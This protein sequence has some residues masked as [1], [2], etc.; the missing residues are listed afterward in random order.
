MNCPLCKHPG[1][2]FDRDEYFQCTH[3][4]G[5]YKNINHY[6]STEEEISRYQEHNNDVN[7]PRYQKFVSP[8]TNYVLNHFTPN[9][10]GLDFGSGTGP[11]A[12]KVLQD[13]GYQIKQYDPL[14]ANDI[15]RLNETYDYIVSCEVIEHFHHPDVEFKLLYKMLKANGA[16]ICMTHLY[17]NQIPFKT[18]YY[19]NDPT[20]V[21]I[22]RTETIK[23]IANFYGFKNFKI[24]KKLVVFEV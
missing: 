13:K 18:W 20:H 23:F 5:L 16:L 14:F 11:V 4:S 12:S 2:P 17:Q 8:I 21:F 6:V 22:Y 9:H 24:D 15:S 3:C 19:R 7:D 10:S 1:I